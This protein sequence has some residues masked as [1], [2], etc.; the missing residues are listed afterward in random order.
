M[1]I[2]KNQEVWRN[3]DCNSPYIVYY[4]KDYS[5]KRAEGKRALIS[6]K[7]KV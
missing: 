3:F 2:Y 7:I 5:Q 6:K 1:D 4:H